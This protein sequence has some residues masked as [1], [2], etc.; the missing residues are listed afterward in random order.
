[1]RFGRD[2]AGVRAAPLPPVPKIAGNNFAILTNGWESM[3]PL[4]EHMSR[5][6]KAAG[7]REVFVVERERMGSG[8]SRP[9]VDTFLDTLSDKIAGAITG[10]GN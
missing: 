7:A 8:A 5:R 4:S 10:L 3:T 2:A 1:V 9:E 6:L